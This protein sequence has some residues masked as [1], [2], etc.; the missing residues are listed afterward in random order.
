MSYTTI[1]SAPKRPRQGAIRS[2]SVDE[3]N[4]VSGAATKM[5]LACCTGAHFSNALLQCR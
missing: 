4:A 5:A 2:L 3:I 1:N